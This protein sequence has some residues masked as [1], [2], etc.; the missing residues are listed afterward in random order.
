MTKYIK[1]IAGGLL[2]IATVFSASAQNAP[3]KISPAALERMALE[4][5]WMS[6]SNA[7]GNVLDNVGRYS[8]TH[9]GYQIEEGSYKRAQI[10]S[11]ISDLTFSTQGGGVFNKM[12]GFY[13]WG[14][15]DY[16]RSNIENAEF[17]ATLFDPLRGM[18]Y[19]IADTHKSP[20]KNQDYNLKFRA[21]TPMLWNSVIFGVEGAFQAAIAA[22]QNDPRPQTLVGMV[23]IKPAVTYTS[24]NNT[25]GLNLHYYSRRED[26]T[27]KNKI[28]FS[29]QMG[30][31]LRGPGFYEQGVVSAS[32]G[33]IPNREYNANNVGAGLQYAY[34]AGKFKIMGSVG[35]DM[36]VE[37]V[38]SADIATVSE[39]QVTP[40]Q[41]LRTYVSVK[42]SKRVATMNDRIFN[43]RLSASY[44]ADN[45]HAVI[46]TGE[47]FQRSNK[48]IEY[49]QQWDPAFEVQA[50]IVTDQS[51]RAEYRSSQFK[52]SLDYLIGCKGNEYSWRINATGSLSKI[53][54][55]FY[56]PKFMQQI[57]AFNGELGVKK[58]IDLGKAGGLLVGV[59]AIM[60]K[61]INAKIAYHGLD[62]D[63]EVYQGLTLRDFKYLS[64]NHY[65]GGATLTYSNG[66]IVKNGVL[67]ATAKYNYVRPD[68]DYNGM[69]KNRS[70]MSL[71]IGINF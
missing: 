17:N 53:D 4:S 41:I 24:G 50:W 26:G 31:A 6:S 66:N 19:L 55:E 44:H 54:D 67:F 40:E 46:F 42:M 38:M 39:K 32:D 30:Y 71:S 58:N 37:D 1:F 43:A 25:V 22:K 63:S 68:S 8:T 51:Y 23:S 61:N 15:F 35:Y 70:I 9:L 3:G 11:K 14:S 28:S 5:F 18:P 33:L 2:S 60:K 57:D 12:K 10:G 47:Y 29:E 65:G 36:K 69:F 27:P 20:W 34:S 45:G 7:A 52:G 48:A 56:M 13:A 64:G 49:L 59:N 21:A 16:K 62:E